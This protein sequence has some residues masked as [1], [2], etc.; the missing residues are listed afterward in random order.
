[1]A[2]VVAGGGCQKV[3]VEVLVLERSLRFVCPVLFVVEKVVAVLDELLLPELD[4]GFEGAR[5]AA[6]LERQ[7]LLRNV[8][9]DCLVR[10]WMDEDLGRMV[11]GRQLSRLHDAFEQVEDDIEARWCVHVILNEHRK[12]EIE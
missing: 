12:R 2:G 3:C 5:V 10:E 9:C 8:I 1:M 6:V 11:L 4:D 7:D